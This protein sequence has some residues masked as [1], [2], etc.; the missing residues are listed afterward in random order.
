MPQTAQ[1]KLGLNLSG[2]NPLKSSEET[3]REGLDP[4]EKEGITQQKDN[5][6]GSFGSP[7]S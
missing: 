7:L 5:N 2:K 3:G 6:K 1:R 4:Q